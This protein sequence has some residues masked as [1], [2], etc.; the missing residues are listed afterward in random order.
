VAGSP[1]EKTYNETIAL[2]L[3]LFYDSPFA[4]MAFSLLVGPDFFQLVCQRE[5]LAVLIYIYCGVLFTNINEWWC[6]GLGKRIVHELSLPAEVLESNP[7]IASALL[8]TKKQAS[9]STEPNKVLFWR[10]FDSTQP[11]ESVENLLHPDD[12]LHSLRSNNISAATTPDTGRPRNGSLK[13]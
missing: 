4:V 3:R 6:D 11:N 12:N 13:C 5:P 1:D 10:I 8:W 9:K 7:K 2:L